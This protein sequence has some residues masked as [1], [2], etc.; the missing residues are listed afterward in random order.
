VQGL[1][2]E[3]IVW[4][5]NLSDR[6]D[7]GLSQGGLQEVQR[8]ERWSHCRG[9]PRNRRLQRMLRQEEDQPPGGFAARA[10][11]LFRETPLHAEALRCNGAALPREFVGEVLL[12]AGRTDRPGHPRVIVSHV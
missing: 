4:L 8:G 3:A 1:R 7:I 11:L 10:G 9:G 6:H 12:D 2:G 5:A